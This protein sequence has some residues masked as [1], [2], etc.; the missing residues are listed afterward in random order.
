MNASVVSNNTER[1]V[2][3]QLMW[4]LGDEY[5]NKMSNFMQ[6]ICYSY[7]INNFLEGTNPR[8]S[9]HAQMIPVVSKF[10]KIFKREIVFIL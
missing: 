2:L 6:S 10:C 4:T 3:L 1:D 7:E 9:P 5:G 8:S